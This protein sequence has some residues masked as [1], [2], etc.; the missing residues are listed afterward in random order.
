MIIHRRV[1][2]A[3]PR[4]W[5]AGRNRMIKFNFPKCRCGRDSRYKCNYDGEE[6]WS[7]QKYNIPCQKRKLE[8]KD[9]EDTRD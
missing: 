5:I 8:E 9:N 1:V 2:T 6:F 3:I 4:Y 7:C